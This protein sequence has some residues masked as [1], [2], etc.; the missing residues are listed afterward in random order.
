MSNGT[1]INPRDNYF[2]RIRGMYPGPG[3]QEGPSYCTPNTPEAAERFRRFKT[4]VNGAAANMQLT[5]T[6]DTDNPNIDEPTYHLMIHVAQRLVDVKKRQAMEVPELMEKLATSNPDDFLI[7]A[8][9]Y[10]LFEPLFEGISRGQ[11]GTWVPPPPP[12]R[13]KLR[14][15]GL[16]AVAGAGLLFTA[17][18]ALVP[19]KWTLHGIRPDEV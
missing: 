3:G 15:G 18:A 14:R 12:A 7:I 2:C 9:D 4:W 17:A 13:Y 16:A 10:P 8:T 1:Q 6:V 19:K 5:H 11:H